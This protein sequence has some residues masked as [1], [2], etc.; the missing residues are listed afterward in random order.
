MA[1][2]L[3]L[4]T[5]LPFVQRSFIRYAATHRIMF[6]FLLNFFSFIQEEGAAALAS[7]SVPPVN[8]STVLNY[9]PKKQFCFEWKEPFNN[10]Q[11]I[12][13]LE[14]SITKIFS[15]WIINNEIGFQIS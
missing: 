13:C 7:P 4:L 9:F 5:G 1:C 11:I 14:V 15:F 12:P 2:L 6:L 8:I 10:I 3:L